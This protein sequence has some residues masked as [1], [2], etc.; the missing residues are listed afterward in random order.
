MM[1]AS[2]IF[3]SGPTR[4]QRARTVK[5]WKR[6]MSLVVD[7]KSYR[8]RRRQV[9]ISLV[10]LAG[11]LLVVAASFAAALTLAGAA[12]FVTGLGLLAISLA[13]FLLRWTSKVWQAF[14]VVVVVTGLWLLLVA[15]V[16]ETALFAD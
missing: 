10:A 1:S 12:L 5:D 7:P 16:L 2:M 9:A 3:Q 13:S 6:V 15:Q 14:L 8:T 11:G 4:N